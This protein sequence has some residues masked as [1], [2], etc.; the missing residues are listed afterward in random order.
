[1]LSERKYHPIAKKRAFWAFRSTLYYTLLGFFKFFGQNIIDNWTSNFGTHIFWTRKDLSY[2]YGCRKMHYSGG[3]VIGP[4]GA[5]AP[6]A[7]GSITEHPITEPPRGEWGKHMSLCRGDW[8]KTGR[9]SLA[10]YISPTNHF[11]SLKFFFYVFPIVMY[12]PYFFHN[13]IINHFPIKDL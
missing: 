11:I 8:S 2:T 1:M 5:V 6:W 9:F 10:P 3:P 13:F 4:P 7:G 12:P